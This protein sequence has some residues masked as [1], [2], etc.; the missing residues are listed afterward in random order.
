MNF[1]VF[2]IFLIEFCSARR[3]SRE[4]ARIKELFR[5]NEELQIERDQLAAENRQDCKIYFDEIDEINDE[6]DVRF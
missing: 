6:N 3:C 2:G 1:L 4:K 5:E